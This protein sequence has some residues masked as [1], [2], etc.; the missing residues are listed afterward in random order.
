MLRM[1]M[2]PDRSEACLGRLTGWY[3]TANRANHRFVIFS[4]LFSNLSS[5][6]KDAHAGINQPTRDILLLSCIEPSLS[7]HVHAQ[8]TE[9][10][11][12][13]QSSE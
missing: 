5:S 1:Y 12:C 7:M 3:E 13:R 8:Y 11:A 9:Q 6:T 10:F 2:C 4:D